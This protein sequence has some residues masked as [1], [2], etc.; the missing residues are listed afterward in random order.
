MFNSFE[1]ALL[2]EFITQLKYILHHHNPSKFKGCTV[3]YQ[4]EQACA[5]SNNAS[6]A[7]NMLEVK[8][9]MNKEYRNKCEAAFPSWLE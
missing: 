8:K 4:C 5:C 6:V 3:V 2:T 7:D 9:N 1:E